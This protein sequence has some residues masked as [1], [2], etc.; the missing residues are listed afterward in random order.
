M[1]MLL[2]LEGSTLAQALR[3][4]RWGYA[5]ANIGHVFGLALLFGAIVPLDLRRLG[6]APGL[7]ERTL[8][9]LLVPVAAA[10]LLLAL[11][12]GLLLASAR[13]SEYLA[14]PLFLAKMGL[15]VLA[16]LAIAA[17]TL[18]PSAAMGRA[19]AMASLLLWS[20]VIVC[21]RL[22]GYWQD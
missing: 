22:L 16:F 3:V 7:E 8:A 6:L 18:R 17:A 10:G 9:R 2:A 4:S 15:I 21:G 20:A 11:A 13:L 5:A 12:T 14:S 1:E 19:A